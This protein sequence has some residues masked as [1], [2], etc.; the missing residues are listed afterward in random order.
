M[1]EGPFYVVL[2]LIALPS[3]VGAYLIARSVGRADI[4]PGM[5]LILCSAA[6]GLAMMFLM[7]EGAVLMP[8][9]FLLKAPGAFLLGSAIGGAAGARVRRK[10]SRQNQSR[11]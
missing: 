10:R 9:N 6:L 3:G 2:V 11:C 4:S 1:S 8:G 5:V 7:P